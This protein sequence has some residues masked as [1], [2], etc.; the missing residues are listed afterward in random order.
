M[1]THDV[2]V[3]NICLSSKYNEGNLLT[4]KLEPI[5]YFL[6]IAFQGIAA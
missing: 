6:I 1:Q 3:L 2:V 5:R 4:E